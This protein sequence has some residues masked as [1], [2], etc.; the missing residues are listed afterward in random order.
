[1]I[2]FLKLFC[3]NTATFNSIFGFILYWVPLLFCIVG[4]TIRTGKNY[5]I[6]IKER[7]SSPKSYCPTDTIGTL[8]G[9]AIVSIIPIANLWAAIF[10]LAPDF[11]GDLFNYIEKVF[12]KPLVPRKK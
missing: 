8:I 4:Y 12:D 10:S 6:D 5:R 1:M 7:E 2:E 3:V 9:R 11:F